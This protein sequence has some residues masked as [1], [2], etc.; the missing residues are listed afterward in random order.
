MKRRAR[1]HVRNPAG[2]HRRHAEAAT[3]R[4]GDWKRSYVTQH[5]A[6]AASLNNAGNEA[7][8]RMHTLLDEGVPLKTA[9][10]ETVAL[11]SND[12]EHVANF[13]DDVAHQFYLLVRD[14]GFTAEE[15]VIAIGHGVATPVANRSRRRTS[16]NARQRKRTSRKRN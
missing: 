14:H 5:G 2:G 15:A 3:R 8:A 7:V 1:R 4:I 16:K 13:A 12:P 6:S 10:K 11:F 9:Y